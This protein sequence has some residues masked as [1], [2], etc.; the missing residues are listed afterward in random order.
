MTKAERLKTILNYL[1]KI[2]DDPRCELF[3]ETPFQLLVATI[4]SAQCTDKQVNKVTPNLFEKYPT[5]YE[6]ALAD[7]TDIEKLVHSTGFYKNKSK[8]ILLASKMIVEDFDGILPNTLE[9][10]IK[11]PGAG[12]KTANVV[13]GNAFNTAGIVVDTHMLRVSNRLGLTTLSDPVKVEFDL[14]KKIPKE[15]WTKFSHQMV[16]FGR[17]TCKAKKTDCH[18]CDLSSGICGFYKDNIKVGIKRT[19]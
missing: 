17:Y 6:M 5:A 7:I 13:L 2:Y 11:L 9:D 10:L 1:D 3:Y 8:N 12:R 18:L 15:S 19:K 14:M 16:L 4:L